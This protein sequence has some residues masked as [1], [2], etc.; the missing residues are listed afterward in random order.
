M[1]VHFEGNNGRDADVTRCLLMTPSDISRAL[2]ESLNIREASVSQDSTSLRLRAAELIIGAER[3]SSVYCRGSTS[4]VDGKSDRFSNL[5]A[6]GPVLV[7]HFGMKSDTAVTVDRD[8][9]CQRHQLL[10]FGVDGLGC[11]SDCG[12][13]AKRFH[14]IWRTLAQQSHSADHVVSDLSLL[15]AKTSP[16]A[17]S[18]TRGLCNED[19]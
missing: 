15:I 17:R 9:D 6:G 12:K 18:L 5:L 16:T 2:L 10:G 3:I 13:G 8:A 1:N 7:G 4:H 19:E 11:G 14:Q